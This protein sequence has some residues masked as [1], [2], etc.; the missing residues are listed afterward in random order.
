MFNTSVRDTLLQSLQTVINRFSTLNESFQHIEPLMLSAFDAQRIAIFQRRSHQRDLVSRYKSGSELREI[1]L[2]INTQSIAGYVSM[3]QQGVIIN[4]P[5]DAAELNRIHFKLKFEH[6]YD[7]LGEFKTNNILSVPIKHKGI[8]LGVLEILN[9]GEDGFDDSDLALAQ[10]AADVMGR[11]FTY[12]LGGT[13]RPFDYLIKMDIVDAKVMSRFSSHA[14]IEQMSTS[15][16]TKHKVSEQLIGEA[17]SIYYQVPFINY[18]PNNYKLSKSNVQLNVTYFKL[19]QVVILTDELKR[20]IVLMFDPTNTA[21][22]MEIESALGTENY[23]LAFGMPKQ[24][25]CYLDEKNAYS[26]SHKFNQII[27]EIDTVTEEYKPVQK[28]S[29]ED[30]PAI[31]RLV[32]NILFEAKSMGASDIHI[33]PEFQRK[34]LVRMRVDGIVRD[35]NQLPE[36]HHMAVVARIKIMAG[37]DISEK[38]MPQDGKLMFEFGEETVEVRVATIPTVVGEGIVM[39][40]LPNGNAMPLDNINLSSR[41]LHMVKS[42]VTMPH[43]M[44]LVVGPTGCGKTT[45]LHA[46]LGFLNTPDK[47]I[48]TAEDPVE[49]TQYRLQQVQVNRK[50]GFT[51]EKALRAFLRADPD[52]ILIGEM[53]DRET[54]NAGIEAS[55]TG[56]FVLSTLHTN[57]ASETI[58]RLIDMGMDPINFSDACVG[59]VAQR[60][61][62][63]LCPSCKEAYSPSEIE[64]E[65]INRQYGDEFLN[66]LNLTNDFKL[67]K[68]SG[69]QKC[70]NTGYKG[71]TG[72][73]EL[74]VMTP[75]LRSLIFNKSAISEI[76]KQAMQDGM[77][78]LVQD[79][80]VK[81]LKGDTDL[82]QAQILSGASVP[83]FN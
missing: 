14:S 31:V 2:A 18:L 11:E 10:E 51:F 60:L 22:L 78:T 52:I 81:V 24:I 27:G 82:L 26:K 50:V 40:L 9:T 73:H 17:L 5:Y 69:C 45:T 44:L 76:K 1:K 41:N 37:L 53:R 75:E 72:V 59:I 68:G 65:F 57:S 3:T 77:R 61:I 8:L 23:Q 66:E 70:D 62:R 35:I 13:T 16:Q 12:E 48:W 46:I 54:A 15:L 43:G 32:S 6:K 38:R 42:L 47:K 63:T 28:S 83:K 25:L 74:L 7:R 20:L 56:H 34:T 29:S 39:R 71:R 49:I 4:D 79:A 21:L 58:T 64:S 80:I 33:D 36:N 55:L 19:N 67:Y 30:E